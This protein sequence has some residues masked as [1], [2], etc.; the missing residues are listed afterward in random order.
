MNN[1]V[2]NNWAHVKRLLLEL[3]SLEGEARTRRLQSIKDPQLRKEV[4]SCQ[5]AVPGDLLEQP[6][7]RWMNPHPTL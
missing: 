4:T 3:E 2:V 7:V 1:Y 5:Q 6:L